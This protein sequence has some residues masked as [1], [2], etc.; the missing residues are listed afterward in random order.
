MSLLSDGRRLLSSLRAPKDV[1]VE[2]FLEEGRSR[3]TGWGEGKPKDVQSAL[4]QGMSVRVIEDGRQGFAHANEISEERAATLF[5]AAREGAALLPRDAARRLARPG[6][7]APFRTPLDKTLFHRPLKVLQDRLA[8]LEK[9]LLAGDA[10]LKKALGLAFSEDAGG[11]AIVSSAGVAVEDK[12]TSV[13]FSLELMGE[14][15]GETQVAWDWTESLTWSKLDVEG[16][17]R[18]ARERLLTA[19]GAQSIPSG[20]YPVIFEPRMGAEVLGLVSSALSGEAVYKKRS[21]LARRLNKAAASPLVTLVDD[22]RLPGGPASARFDDEGVP[23]RRNVLMAKGVVK[24]FYYDAFTAAKAGRKST[25]NAGRSGFKGAPGPSSTNFY[26]LPGKISLKALMA[27]TPR[28]FVVREL[29]GMHTADPV[30]GDFSLGASGLLWENGKVSRAV[31]GVTLAGSVPDLLKK[32]DAVA[33]DL[34]WQGATGCPTFRVS[35][36]SVGGS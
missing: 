28:A 19:F 6:K 32:I 5:R 22:G 1:E 35:G 34:A 30:S 33:D 13:S 20:T 3:E 23:S 2:L 17:A 31:K 11:H 27:A 14:D 18:A 26:M 10:R 16:P 9:D 25:G 29:L 7:A 12:S 8:S 15:G 4:S 36:L 24:G 21:F